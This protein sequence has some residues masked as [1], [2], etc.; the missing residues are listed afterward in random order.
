[1]MAARADGS[2]FPVELAITRIPAEGPACFTGY[3]RDITERKRSEE[4]LRRSEAYLTEAQKLSLTGSF[5][6]N[7]ATDEHVWSDETFRIFEYD[8]S[9]RI[10]LKLIT[11]RVHPQDLKVFKQ[12]IAVAAKGTDID[13]E[14][15]F[16]IQKGDPP[17]LPG[18]Q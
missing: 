10:T 18:W 8:P 7:V 13:Y 17:A 1:M 16:L 6:W 2:E 14:C 3:L 5:D 9:T 4:E 11:D 15:R 12:A